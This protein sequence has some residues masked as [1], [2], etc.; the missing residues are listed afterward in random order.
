MKDKIKLNWYDAISY[1]DDKDKFIPNRE[2]AK[3]LGLDK[4]WTSTTYLYN[5]AKALVHGE[6]EPVLKTQIRLVILTDKY[7]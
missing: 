7:K 5:T 1:A 6:K 4:C 3:E 2:R